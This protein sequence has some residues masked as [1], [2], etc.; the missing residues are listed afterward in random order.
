[1]TSTIWYVVRS[2][3]PK[4]NSP[5]IMRMIL[6]PNYCKGKDTDLKGLTLLRFHIHMEQNEKLKIKIVKNAKKDFTK[7]SKVKGL[8][9]IG[10]LYSRF[11]AVGEFLGIKLEFSEAAHGSRASMNFGD[12]KGI[13]PA[14][15][16]EYGTDF[17]TADGKLAI[18]RF[19]LDSKGKRIITKFEVLGGTHGG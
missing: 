10:I 17:I 14:N 1:M 4:L 8:E 3:K 5:I 19:K 9:K 6:A 7:P 11:K 16:K 2:Q 12:G 18:M 15:R 13:V